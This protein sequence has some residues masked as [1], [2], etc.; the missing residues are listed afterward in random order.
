MPDARIDFD[1]RDKDKAP[2]GHPRMRK[3]QSRGE[4]NGI[5][6]Q[7]EVDIDGPG[8][9]PRLA[10]AAQDGLDGLG[11]IQEMPGREF[12]FDDEDLIEEPGLEAEADGLGLIDG[13][14]L[15]EREASL[16]EAGAG[17][18]KEGGPVAEIAAQ[19]E[20]ETHVFRKD[21]LS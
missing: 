1:E 3:D 11:D 8:A 20:M 16:L 7:E 2:L 17:A 21:D 10:A 18:S 15:D 13:G 12:G 6:R 9:V 4:E 5:F 14:G 19:A